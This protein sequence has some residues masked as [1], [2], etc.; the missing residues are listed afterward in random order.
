MQ[1]VDYFRKHYQTT[2][3]EEQAVGNLGG[4]DESAR[5]KK[6]KTGFRPMYYIKVR[7]SDGVSSALIVK[8]NSFSHFALQNYDADPRK[9]EMSFDCSCV[10]PT[11]VGLRTAR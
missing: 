9:V 4:R 3:S 5:I 10:D 8:T 6:G 1:D 2:F 7:L 11:L